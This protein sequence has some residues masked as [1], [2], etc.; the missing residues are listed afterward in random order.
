MASDNEDDFQQQLAEAIALSLKPES[1]PYLQDK[2]SLIV[3][4]ESTE[5]EDEA[6]DPKPA[7][8]TVT[9]S[10]MTDEQ[11]PTHSSNGILRGLDRKKMEEERLTRLKRKASMSSSISPPP[12]RRGRLEKPV[13]ASSSRTANGVVLKTWAFGFARDQDIKIEEVLQ[14]DDLKLAVLSSFQWDVEWLLRKLDLNRTEMVF[15]MQAK[16]EVT[17]AQYRTE[18][19]NMPNLR[20]CFP[21]MAGNVNCM[22]SKLQ[23]LFHQ[24]YLRIAV[25]S[26][27]LIT[28]DWGENGGVMENVVFLVDLPRRP[29]GAP[30]S[31]EHLTFFG[32]ELIYFLEAMGLSKSI[33]DNVLRFDFSATTEIAFVHSIGGIH[34]GEQWKRTGYC[35]LSTAIRTL[36]L[37]QNG[38]VM[39]D[40]VASSIGSLNEQ[41]LST[42]F[43][44]AHGND[45]LTE[46][47]W[48]N[49]VQPQ[50]RRQKGAP[51]EELHAPREAEVLTRMRTD[52]RIYFPTRDTVVRSRGGTAV[53]GT[54]CLH[55][56]WYDAPSFPRTLFRDAQSRRAGLLMHSK[57]LFARPKKMEP[58]EGLRRAWAYVGSANISESA[59]GRLVKDKTTKQ[60]RLNCRNWECGVIIPASVPSPDLPDD[61]AG[62]GGVIGMDVFM[63]RV[64][65]PLRIPAE[66]Y[67]SRRPW[68]YSEA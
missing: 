53:G 54:I 4:D 51:S 1:S 25:P 60:P 48:R 39:V 23:L 63:G 3:I 47:S 36:G 68:F 12:S 7:R 38:D 16:D 2:K 67:G 8:N 66:L 32:K 5:S 61:A 45:P 46:Y 13:E 40:F 58:R 26:A 43:L 49:P 55:P 59:W 15:V 27:N 19:M 34:P 42:I 50:P 14:K 52:F 18:T 35:G 64:P 29:D 10:M 30:I 44:A 28:Y 33:I 11:P 17:K 24:D 22:H 65:V 37:H 62:A 31:K 56:K 21:S 6:A 57:M 20:L 41:F 9:P